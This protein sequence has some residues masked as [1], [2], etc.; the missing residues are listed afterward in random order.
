MSDMDDWM[1]RGTAPADD[2]STPAVD[3][4]ALHSGALP[5]H[6]HSG[7]PDG[8]QWMRRHPD[9]DDASDTAWQRHRAARWRS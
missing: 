7:P 3:V 2:D 1:R 5:F 9:R 8:E 4:A 6:H